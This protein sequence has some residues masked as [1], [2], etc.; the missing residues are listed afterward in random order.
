LLVDRVVVDGWPVAAAAESM[1]VSRATAHKWLRRWREF[2]PAGLVDRSSRPRS[3][4]SAV[5]AARAARIVAERERTGW[6]PHRLAALTGEC[7]ST[8]HR[9]LRRAGRSR[10]SDRDPLTQ[11]VIRYQRERPGELLHVDVKKFA[12]IPD[13]GGHKVLGRS[14]TAR[15]LQTASR[16]TGRAATVFVHT[17]I[18][19]R[20][21]IAFVQARGSERAE[22]CTAFLADALDHFA[23]LGVTV[24][25]VMTDNAKNYVTAR[26]FQALLTDRGVR[27]VRIKPYRPQTNGKVERFHLT[28]AREWAYTTAYASERDRLATLPA[29]I[30]WYNNARPHTALDGQPP[31]STVNNVPGHYT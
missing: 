31:M 30:D 3:C 28:L 26:S 12:F 13:G 2:G 15:Q 11:V 24:E 17:A 29:F 20:S 16:R 6:G 19:D 10:L 21:R 1:G 22:D 7:R 8:V 18:D 4:P 27:H 5:P 14:A 25:R 9:V 23:S